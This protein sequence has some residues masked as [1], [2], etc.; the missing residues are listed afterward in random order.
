MQIALTD[1]GFLL[2]LAQYCKKMHFFGQYKDD[3]SGK[4]HRP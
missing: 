1:L 4:K 3:N 2:R